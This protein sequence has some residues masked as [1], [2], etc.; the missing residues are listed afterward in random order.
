MLSEFVCIDIESSMSK[1]THGCIALCVQKKVEVEDERWE[2]VN[3][4][5]RAI[6]MHVI[7]PSE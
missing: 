3:L 4:G 2:I 1:E 6:W 5:L 7:K